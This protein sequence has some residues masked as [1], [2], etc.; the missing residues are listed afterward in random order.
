[1]LPRSAPGKRI[2]LDCPDEVRR[3]VDVVLATRLV[4]KPFYA[5]ETLA[6]VVKRHCPDI[7]DGPAAHGFE[8]RFDMPENT[9]KAL[10]KG[11]MFYQIR[12]APA[13]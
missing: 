10:I 6:D 13:H 4:R 9:H 7:F 3:Q 8:L 5:R 11:R 2:H 1:M 12:R